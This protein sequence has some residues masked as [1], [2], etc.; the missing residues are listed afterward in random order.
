MP[1]VKDYNMGRKP[2]VEF[3]GKLYEFPS[4]KELGI[5]FPFQLYIPNNIR[6]NCDLIVTGRTPGEPNNLPLEENI[7]LAK[8]MKFSYIS[9]VLSSKYGNPMLL[10]VIPRCHGIQSTSLGYLCHHNDYHEAIEWIDKGWL[11]ISKEELHLFDNLDEQI[12]K[13]IEYSLNF[14]KSKGYEADEKIV[15]NGYSAAASFASLFSV[16]H[17]E[18]IKA[19]IAGGNGG[20]IFLPLKEYKE[21]TLDY[22]LGIN[23]L[24]NFNYELFK[25]IKKFYY[26]GSDDFNTPAI[27][28]CE[29]QIERYDESGNPI[30]VRD[31]S[32]NKIPV[33]DESGSMILKLDKDGNMIA[34]YGEGYY[35]NYQ[36]NFLNKGI[37]PDQ[38]KR[39]EYAQDIY[40]S[41]GIDAIFNKYPGNHATVNESD[42]LYDDVFN[43]YEKNILNR[44][45]NL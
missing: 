36:I 16:L 30:F 14:L 29:M 32:G 12:L 25:N 31:E 44:D 40:E 33:K 7:E 5:N 11:N 20:E 42:A 34:N 35:S 39:F 17:P 18:H 43:F 9:R 19:I 27:P 10:P 38:Q 26:I 8:T 1:E 3:D 4:N 23:D 6:A 45:K 28:M 37:S 41:L 21:W 24:P 22:P 2:D 15:I 13:M